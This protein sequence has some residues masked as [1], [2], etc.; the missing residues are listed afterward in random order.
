VTPA[1]IVEKGG[2]AG[3]RGAFS[4]A[5]LDARRGPH[6]PTSSTPAR[7][8]QSVRR[9]T[10]TVSRRP[11][12]FDKPLI[13]E[14]EARDLW[15]G[16]DGSA[17]VLGHAAY[18]GVVDNDRRLFSLTTRPQVV[19]DRLVGV[20]ASSG[21]RAVLEE[22]I[23]GEREARSLLYLLLDDLPVATLVSGYAV[24]RSGRPQVRQ[25]ARARA[26][27][28]ICAGYRPDGTMAQ[29]I[30]AI[31]SSPVVLG[32]PA[33][34]LL[35][36]DPLAWHGLP[37]LPGH[38]MRRHRRLDIVPDGDCLAF[39][40]LFRDSHT[41]P[42]G[43]ETVVHEYLVWGTADYRTLVIRDIEA[44]ARVLPWM[45]CPAAAAS[46]ARLVGSPVSDLRREVRQELT[47]V[48]TCTHLNDTLRSL[49][50][51]TALAGYFAPGL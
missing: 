23:P 20:L 40:V 35:S 30:D 44:E 34:S 31:G 51:I 6:N 28:G 38:S 49:E 32:P 9:T 33:P 1:P 25:G 46:P 14:G 39:D 42:D 37:P 22:A 21:F 47:G 27:I 41:A 43:A 5:E 19:V 13:L 18:E 50:D 3:R 10:T 29:S 26:V 15:T 4:P 24:S 12:G 11:N 17:T 8:P 36:D 48:T 7:A 45:E 16:P 2:A